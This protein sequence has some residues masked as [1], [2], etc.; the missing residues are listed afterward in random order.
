[1]VKADPKLIRAVGGIGGLSDRGLARVLKA[2]RG[3]P[4][5]LDS[6]ISARKISRA[7][8][9]FAKDVCNTVEM[10]QRNG[11]QFKWTYASPKKLLAFICRNH[12]HFWKPFK[13]LH[14]KRPS[15]KHQPWKI[16]TDL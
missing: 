4:E 14:D 3:C 8:N 2:C 9:S 11:K 15:S 10:D 12:E 13:K 5:L 1:M 16:N 7:L 6:E